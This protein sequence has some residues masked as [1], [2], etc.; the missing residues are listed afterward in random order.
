MADYR[1]SRLP[2]ALKKIKSNY[3][4]IITPLPVP[5]DVE[6]L[7]KLEK[8]ETR[9]M[10]GAYPMVWKSAKDINVYDHWG[11][12]WLDFTS[13][14]FVANAGHANP[15]IKEAIIAVLD[16][17]LTHA[18][19]YSTR[20]RLEYLEYLIANT[21]KFCEKAFLLSAGTEATEVALKLMRM[22]GQKQHPDKNIIIALNGNWH[23]RTMGAQFM[24]GNEGQKEWIGYRD[25]FMHHLP[26]PYDQEH[27]VTEDLEKLIEKLGNGANNKIAGIMLETYQGWGA[28]FYPDKFIKEL[29]AAS[30]KYKFLIAFDEM[31][32]GFGRTGKMFGYQHYDITPDLICCGKGASS[33]L[34][35][36]MVLGR[37]K[38]LDLPDIG[39]MSSTHS[40]HPVIVAA[41]HANL[42]E[43]VER[44]LCLNA[45]KLG[46]F[47]NDSL[48]A[49]REKYSKTYEITINSKG[50]VAGFVLYDMDG[51]PLSDECSEICEKC[52]QAGLLVVHTGRESIKIA[53]PL[54]IE[55]DALEEGLSVFCECVAQVLG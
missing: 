4:K 14:I 48:H 17:D 15:A 10:H 21:P 41:G 18:Y 23:G 2:Q 28:Y 42:K 37:S 27:S 5:A 55:F 7:D 1:F 45:H 31:Q 16:D 3:R 50:L 33:S 32:S 8:L 6:S 26:F 25:P 51:K 29:K 47:L 19:N 53:P 12:K 49:I 54:T 46:K 52:F 40:A 36:S 30:K 38:L 34:P 13:T 20:P 43:I 24:A 35:L 11:N 39:S 22:N 9:A 44:N